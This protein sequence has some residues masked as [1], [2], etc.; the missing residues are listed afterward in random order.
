MAAA[1][2]VTL[3]AAGCAPV[4]DV[5]PAPKANDPRCADVMVYLPETL[6]GLARRETNSQATAAWGEPSA[7]VVRCGV[8]TPSTLAT[9]PCVT[10]NGV[11]WLAV[12]GG[13]HWTLT[14]YGRTPAVEVLFDPNTVPSSNVLPELAASVERVPAQEECLSTERETDFR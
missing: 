7:V 2:A 9:Q 1:S 5:E 6:S 3:L 4:V 11:D 10:A 8:D 12:E 14:S 13:D